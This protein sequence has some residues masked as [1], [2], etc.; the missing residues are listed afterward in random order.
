MAAVLAAF[1]IVSIAGVVMWQR[2]TTSTTITTY[3]QCAAAKGSVIL[4]IF[5]EQCVTTDR[6]TFTRDITQSRDAT[7][8]DIPEWGIRI[9]DIDADARYTLNDTGTIY[10]TTAALEARLAKVTDCTSGLRGLTLERG[11][12]VTLRPVAIVEPACITMKSELAEEIKV[13]KQRLRKAI[14][15]TEAIRNVCADE[16]ELSAAC[17]KASGV[18]E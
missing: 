14:T 3:E 17:A 4:D 2:N 6:R 10:V 1:A 12:G 7:S 8:L 16:Q 9:T 5:P 18:Y 15:N 11:E 13:I